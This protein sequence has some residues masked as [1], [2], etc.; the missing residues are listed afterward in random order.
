MTPTQRR[1]ALGGGFAAA[2]LLFVFAWRASL[3][4]ATHPDHDHGILNLDAGGRLMIVRRDGSERNL[5]GRPGKVLVVH[6]FSLSAPEAAGEL[7]ALFATQETLKADH[8]VDWV[9]LA[10]DTDFVSLDRW[11]G[12]K[13]LV[14]TVPESLYVD[15]GGDTTKK[16]NCKRPLDTMFFNPEGKLASQSRG[17]ANWA[18]EASSRID[19]ARGGATIE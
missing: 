7:A 18:L 19:Q 11:L 6:F 17:P 12:E 13:K 2:A 15:A 1:L 4:P 10:R 9:L 5:V 14:P 3:V 16:L 8:G